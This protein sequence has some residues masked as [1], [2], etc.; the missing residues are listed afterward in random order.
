M[1]ICIHRGTHEIGGSCVELA[2]DG[3]RIAIDLGLP[4]DA[5]NNDPKWLPNIAGITSPAEDFLGIII[6]HPHQDHYGLLAHVPE[7]MP[8]AMGM[9][10]RRILDTASRFMP[11][12]KPHLGNL[13][14]KDRQALTLG[15]FAITPFKMDHSAYDA[16]ALL[17]EAGGRR[18]FYSGDFRAHGRKAAQFERLIAAPPA[19]I[20]CLLLEG[21]SLARLDEDQHFDTETDLEDQFAAAFKRIAGLALVFASGQNID[22]LV[23]IYRAALKTNRQLVLDLYT[24]EILAATE[25]AHLPQGH[26]ESVRVIIPHSQSRQASETENLYKRHRCINWAKLHELGSKAVMLCRSSMINQLARSGNLAGAQALYSMW[27]GYLEDGKL[28]AQLDALNIPLTK[29]HTSGHADTPTLKRLVAALQ[30][31]TV[32]PIHSQH[33]ELYESLFPNVVART[34]GQWWSI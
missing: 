6:S 14:L 9:A 27:D 21:T 16:Y 28:Q 5:E 32:T 4:L 1:E 18:L 33:P 29:I 23:T 11:G 20:D 15:P 22:R 34:D 10:A 25:N 7:N 12:P 24:S 26:W 17:I 30:P 19:A 2:H 13:E 31:N 8:V 3:Y